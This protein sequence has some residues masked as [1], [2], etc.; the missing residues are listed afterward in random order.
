MSAQCLS[1][2]QLRIAIKERH[3]RVEDLAAHIGVEVRTLE[4]R[5]GEQLHM[6]PKAWI[7]TERMTAAVRLLTEGLSNKEV[8]FHLS[9]QHE[10]SFCREFKRHF[11]CGPRLFVRRRITDRRAEGMSRLARSAALRT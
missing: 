6:T 1:T 7:N 11:G 5:F 4:R 2:N 10:S 3:F 9:Y 8:A